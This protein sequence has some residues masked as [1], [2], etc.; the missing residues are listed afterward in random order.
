MTATAPDATLRLLGDLATHG[1]LGSRFVIT[2]PRGLT[3]TLASSHQP[4]WTRDYVKLACRV[5]DRLPAVDPRVQPVGAA[6]LD[7]LLRLFAADPAA[8]DF[9]H[10]GLLDDGWYRAIA[11]PDG[12]LLSVAGT[13][14]V[15]PHTGTAA[16]GNVATHPSAR[17][18]G[19]ARA[20]VSTLTRQLLRSG[21]PVGLN[22]TVDNDGARALYTSMGF[23]EV[24]AYEEA[25]LVARSAGSDRVPR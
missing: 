9:F 6:D 20:T 1:A 15:D 17:R 23:D 18:R 11:G 16:I 4:R 5:A 22:V 14:V 8:G 19:L 12:E 24:H 7:R 21:A 25:E 3:E 2:G 10:P 13:H